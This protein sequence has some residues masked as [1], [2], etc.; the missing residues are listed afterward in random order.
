MG[1][2]QVTTLSPERFEG[3]ARVLFRFVGGTGHAEPMVP[4]ARALRDAGHR[5]AL[6]GPREVP[7][8]LEGEEPARF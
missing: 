1:P 5:V 8:E 2:D 4:I 6:A 3:W 7:I